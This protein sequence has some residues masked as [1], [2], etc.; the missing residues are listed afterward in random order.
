MR[1]ETPISVAADVLPAVPGW[2][3]ETL[4]SGASVHTATLRPQVSRGAFLFL[5]VLVLPGSGT[6]H[7]LISSSRDLLDDATFRTNDPNV[8]KGWVVKRTEE[9]LTETH[10]LLQ[11]L[12]GLR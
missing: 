1:Q 3:V 9:L 11:Q 5:S 7:A 6:I 10:R 8:G 12:G 2:K 4:G